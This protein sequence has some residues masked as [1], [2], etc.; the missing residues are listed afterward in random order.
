MLP[1]TRCLPRSPNWLCHLETLT[2]AHHWH[3]PNPRALA[4]QPAHAC[5][6]T[7]PAGPASCSNPALHSSLCEVSNS[8]PLP[9]A[10][11]S[12]RKPLETVWKDASST[13]DAYGSPMS[14]ITF[15]ADTN[16][17]SSCRQGQAWQV[18]DRLG[19]RARLLRS[20]WASALGWAW[21]RL[22]LL[23]LSSS[24]PNPPKA[25]SKQSVVS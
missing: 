5:S 20:C 10:P 24:F 12:P 8:L 6:P 2:L 19:G 18:R 7:H 3:Y 23:K 4:K 13:P 25:S 21:P 22:M 11:H 1:L 16:G 14:F 9:P 17:F 15:L